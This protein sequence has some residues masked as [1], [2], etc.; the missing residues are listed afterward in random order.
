MLPSASRCL[1][2]LIIGLLHL[3]GNGETRMCTRI[4]Q[5]PCS[6]DQYRVNYS[7]SLINTAVQISRH[8]G[9]SPL[10]SRYKKPLIFKNWY[11]QLATERQRVPKEEV[12]NIIGN[13]LI[14]ISCY[15]M[16]GDCSSRKIV[17]RKIVKRE[18]FNVEVCRFVNEY[19]WCN[20]W[21]HEHIWL[22]VFGFC[23]RACRWV[24]SR[25]LYI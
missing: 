10:V 13:V 6:H 1:T 15:I 21:V 11:S 20:I 19:I 23:A 16:L 7:V 24:S 18:S 3:S 22:N 5:M 9:I 4:N 2:S 25:R 17:S 14:Y 8:I 12:I